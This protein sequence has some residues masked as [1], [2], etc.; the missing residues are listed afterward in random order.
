MKS[1]S[2]LCCRHYPCRPRALGADV[3]AP[4]LFHPFPFSP[5]TPSGVPSTSAFSLTWSEL[6]GSAE[7][8]VANAEVISTLPAA[9]AAHGAFL[10]QGVCGKWFWDLIR[11]GGRGGLHGGLSQQ[12][13]KMDPHS[14]GLA[15]GQSE[16]CSLGRGLLG[17]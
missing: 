15:S 5:G 1:R 6:G 13:P 17:E 2:N 3:G 4:E 10:A 7:M 14:R 11:P 12:Q 9:L 8:G 16:F